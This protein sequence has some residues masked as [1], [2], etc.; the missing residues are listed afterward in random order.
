GGAGVSL[1]AGAAS[2]YQ[3]IE[4]LSRLP[5]PGHLI[6]TLA[7][8]QIDGGHGGRAAMHPPDHLPDGPDDVHR[9][10]RR[11]DDVAEQWREDEVVF[12]AEQDDRPVGRQ[13]TLELAGGIHAGEATADNYD[14]TAGRVHTG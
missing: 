5:P 3:V 10:D 1:G 13:A 4:C 6:L 2:G 11:P 8:D 7:G 12:F 14:G 9:I